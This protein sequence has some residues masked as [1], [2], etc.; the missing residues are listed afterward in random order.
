MSRLLRPL[1]PIFEIVPT[2]LVT[3]SA[4]ELGRFGIG[5]RLFRFLVTVRANVVPTTRVSRRYPRTRMQRMP[6]FE[7]AY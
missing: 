1:S 3:D 7:S 5:V 2:K 6:A 4:T